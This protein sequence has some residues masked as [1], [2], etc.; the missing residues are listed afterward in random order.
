MGGGLS[1]LDPSDAGSDTGFSLFGGWESR[2][3]GTT[4]PYLEIRGLFHDEASL[5]LAVG[6]NFMIN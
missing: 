1:I 4:N 2:T 5:Q 6:L 3:Y